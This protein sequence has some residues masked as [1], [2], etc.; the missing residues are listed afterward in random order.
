MGAKKT[1]TQNATE[2]ENGVKNDDVGKLSGEAEKTQET[3][4]NNATEGKESFIY[5]G[6]TTKTGLIQNTIFTGTRESVEEYLEKTVEEIPQ[7]KLLIVP[8]KSLAE[9]R[10]KVRKAGTLLNKYYNDVLSLSRKNNG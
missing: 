10:A 4:N 9:S 8:T 2:A 6:P 5:L 1:A 3:A 7:V